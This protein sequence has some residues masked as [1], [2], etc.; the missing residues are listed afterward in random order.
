MVRFPFWGYPYRYPYYLYHNNS[1]IHNNSQCENR[2][3]PIEN[4]NN[5]TSNSKSE[6]NEKNRDTSSRSISSQNSFSKSIL[7]FSLNWD[8]FSNIEQP[9]IEILGI[10][11]FL[12]DLIILGLLFILY[13]EEVKD[14]MLFI[15]LILL[16]LS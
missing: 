1:N 13:K 7:P 10:K 15:I 12:D 14:E 4:S 11:L 16:L 5:I 2:E 8:G 6:K 9:I 3:L